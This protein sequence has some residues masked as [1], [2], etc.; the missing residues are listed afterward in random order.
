VKWT[1][2]L[3]LILLGSLVS[4]FT[5][6]IVPT[7]A[8]PIE[9]PFTPHSGLGITPPIDA[10]QT[11]TAKFTVKIIGS[12]SEGS[13]VIIHRTDRTYL[14]LTNAHVVS[15]PGTYQIRMPDRRQYSATVLKQPQFQS[16]DLAL[17]QLVS[18]RNYSVASIHRN[19]PLKAG[20]SIYALG[21]PIDPKNTNAQGLR[22]T[23]G[24]LT[25]RLDTDLEDGYQL[26]YTSEVEK[27]MS[28]G[29]LVNEWGDLV[30]LQGQGKTLWEVE[31][32]DSNGNIPCPPMQ[33]FINQS[34]WGIPIETI[35]KLLPT[36]VPSIVGPPLSA[37]T[38]LTRVELEY[39]SREPSIDSLVLIQQAEAARQCR[40]FQETRFPTMAFP[41]IRIPSR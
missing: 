3:G 37:Q 2:K 29:P 17:L 34:N 41:L 30:G 25:I 4:T 14:I 38:Q 23:I 27:G 33:K 6:P 5:Y 7:V 21:F 39:P 28:G 40:P 19:S 36:I 22:F 10:V 18:D 20:N 35:A 15:Q 11:L 16:K 9:L 24:I 32:K 12:E 1:F 8:S 31:F 26:G 13:G